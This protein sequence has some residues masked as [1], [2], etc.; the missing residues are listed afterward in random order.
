MLTFAFLISLFQGLIYA[1]VQTRGQF[2]SLARQLFFGKRTDSSSLNRMKFTAPF[3]D[4]AALR[5]ME[6]PVNGSTVGPIKVAEAIP[7]RIDSSTHGVWEADVVNGVNTWSIQIESKTAL[8]I[9]LVFSNFTLPP[10]GELYIMNDVV[11]L[12]AFTAS[13]NNK[14]SKEFAIQPVK[15]ESVFLIFVEPMGASPAL[16]ALVITQVV[17]GYRS[18]G[19]GFE[20]GE[21][22]TSGSCEVDVCCLS[23]WV[24]IWRCCFQ[25]TFLNFYCFVCYLE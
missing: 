11:T 8:S 12:G 5:A 7:V 3:H 22:D 6:K 13:V 14:Q 10:A 2:D 15:G 20:G 23:S 18:L 19:I 21:K 25:R 17:H 16:D 4:S 9:A 24:D 1:Q